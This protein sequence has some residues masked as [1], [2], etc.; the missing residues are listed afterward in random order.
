MRGLE[1]PQGEKCARQTH[2]HRR[3]RFRHVRASSWRYH[4]ACVFPRTFVGKMRGRERHAAKGVRR[5]GGGFEPCSVITQQQPLESVLDKAFDTRRQ[6]WLKVELRESCRRC[7]TQQACAAGNKTSPSS[8]VVA[9]RR[10]PGC[11]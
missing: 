8:G 11:P 2:V 9:P 7:A 4:T 10:V 1:N 6:G 5:R 3:G